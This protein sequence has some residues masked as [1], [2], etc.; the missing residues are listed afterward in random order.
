[1]LADRE[2]KELL[3][4]AFDEFISFSHNDFTSWETLKCYMRGQIIFY[5]THSNKKMKTRLGELTSAISNLDQGYL[6]NPS[7]ELLKQCLDLQAESKTH[8]AYNMSR[9]EMWI[10]LGD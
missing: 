10:F 2:F 6:L 5:S 4:N 7:Q 9:G 8:S 3:K 1:M